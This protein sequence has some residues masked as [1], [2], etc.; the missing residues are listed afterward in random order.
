MTTR[1]T[2]C[3]KELTTGGWKVRGSENGQWGDEYYI[4]YNGH[5]N[6]KGQIYGKCHKGGPK[7]S[8]FKSIRNFIQMVKEYSTH[9]HKS[10]HQSLVLK[11]A[12]HLNRWKQWYKEGN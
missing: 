8:G 4:L 3:L 11:D 2:P 10:W 1:H 6:I 9:T 5:N 7:L 12:Q